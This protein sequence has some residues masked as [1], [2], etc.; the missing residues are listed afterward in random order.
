MK[1]LK[2][3][4]RWMKDEVMGEGNITALLFRKKE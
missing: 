3:N 4:I 2:L 1:F